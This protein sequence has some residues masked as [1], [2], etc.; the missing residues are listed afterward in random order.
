LT[1]APPV[2]PSTLEQR[3]IE[4]AVVKTAAEVTACI[5]RLSQPRLQRIPHDEP[6]TTLPSLTYG[7]EGRIGLPD[8]AR[9][10]ET[11]VARSTEP[12][13]L[14]M[15][16]VLTGQPRLSPRYRVPQYLPRTSRSTSPRSNSPPKPL[17]SALSR[18]SP[19]PLVRNITRAKKAAPQSSHGKQLLDA[20]SQGNIELMRDLI[21]NH[22]TTAA[23]LLDAKNSFGHTALMV[24]CQRGQMPAVKLLIDSGA[25]LGDSDKFGSGA[26]HYA[27]KAASLPIVCLLIAAGADHHATNKHGKTPRDMAQAD[28]EVVVFL[29]TLAKVEEAKTILAEEDV[30]RV[31]ARGA[32]R[33]ASSG[34]GGARTAY[35]VEATLRGT[36]SASKSIDSQATR[37]VQARSASESA[38]PM[39]KVL[40]P[41]E[42]GA[43]R[44]ARLA[45]P[46]DAWARAI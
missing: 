14:D 7:R 25:S 39:K 31:A 28:S 2:P 20:T 26:L 35:L 13:R 18:H 22:K 1:P 5:Q 37:A 45:P 38:I 9:V 21:A 8:P 15:P 34:P 46:T 4:P 29:E 43:E 11:T 19:L 24:A 30:M 41:V 32:L 16:V 36:I 6:R 3:G 10:G 44:K 12:S 33:V 17:L 27:C 23:D 42:D 40:E